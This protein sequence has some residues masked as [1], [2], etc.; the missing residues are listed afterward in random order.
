MIRPSA[1]LAI[2]A[3]SML[4][5]QTASVSQFEV[6]SVKP[7]RSASNYDSGLRTRRGRLDA[8]NVTLKRCIMGAYGVGP[9]QVSGG[10]VWL[11]SDRF[12]ILTKAEQPA[13]DAEMML[14]LQRL[15]ADRF[16][17]TLHREVRSMHAYVLE[18]DKHGPKLEKAEPG[19]SSTNTSGGNSSVTIDA[20]RSDMESF[21]KV[22]ARQLALPVVNRTGLEGAYN[23][24]LSWAPETNRPSDGA[25]EAS[26][27]TAIREQ[28][29]LRLRSEIAPVEI[30]V[31][32][33]AEKPS[34]N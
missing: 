15:L 4:C 27:F 22:L 17:L 14:M 1:V 20:R 12:E 29:G 9:H 30:L 5:A 26:I 8:Y 6:A 23:L 7:T 31:I 2:C 3:A 21:A 28:L 33:R 18:V 32:D 24:K 25:T 34:E 11:D 10:P 19:E 13:G 16:K